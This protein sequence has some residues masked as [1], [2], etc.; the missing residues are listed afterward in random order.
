MEGLVEI[1]NSCGEL[2]QWIQKTTWYQECLEEK[3]HGQPTWAITQVLGDWGYPSDGDRPKITRL[4]Q[5]ILMEWAQQSGYQIS[6]V[7]ESETDRIREWSDFRK[8]A[9]S[10]LDIPELYR[11]V[12]DAGRKSRSFM[13]EWIS[14]C[15]G[16]N[17]EVSWN[18]LINHLLPDVLYQSIYYPTI[19]HVVPQ[20]QRK[21]RKWVDIFQTFQLVYTIDTDDIMRPNNPDLSLERVI[22]QSMILGPGIVD[23]N[24]L[25]LSCGLLPVLHGEGIA[26]QYVLL[27]CALGYT[28]NTVITREEER[29]LYGH[30]IPYDYWAASLTIMAQSQSLLQDVK[31]V[32]AGDF[33]S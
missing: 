12:D 31:L 30:S 14:G 25:F 18:K 20:L 24:A 27:C 28:V 21:S 26:L 4:L 10:E 6:I 22:A 7:P 11:C 33:H 1:L 2:V 17:V 23:W 16:E 32:A 5:Y 8:Q 29:V 15:N 13:R 9:M 19:G 3:Q